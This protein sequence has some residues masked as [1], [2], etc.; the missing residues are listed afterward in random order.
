[1]GRNKLAPTEG[2]ILKNIVNFLLSF[3]IAVV[4]LIKSLLRLL[5]KPFIGKGKQR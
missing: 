2:G 3:G 5:V 4:W 1:M